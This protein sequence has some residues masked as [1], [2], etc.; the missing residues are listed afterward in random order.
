MTKVKVKN[1]KKAITSEIR[2]RVADALS[3]STIAEDTADQI[4][5]RTRLGKGVDDSGKQGSLKPLGA[6][7]RPENKD[8][9][10]DKR[11]KA[12]L[13]GELSELT[14]PK[15]SN[16]TY[17]GQLLD[18]IKGRVKGFQI[19]IEILGNRQDGMS[20]DQLREYVEEKRPFFKLSNPEKKALIRALKK[21]ILGK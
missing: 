21:M 13:A 14:T 2:K 8:K 9:Y 20:N 16:L 19:I 5:K 6:F 10:I 11:K 1:V 18:A 12:R 17:S 3:N 4:R 15:K 7:A